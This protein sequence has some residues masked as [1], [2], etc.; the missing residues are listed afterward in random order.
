M[1]SK[2]YPPAVGIVELS[3]Q[4]AYESAGYGPEDIDV[5]QVYDTMAPAELWDIEKLGFCKTG[6]AAAMLRDGVFDIGSKIPVNTDGGLM[7]RGHPLGA[8]GLGQIFE[9][10]TQLRGEAGSRQVKKAKIGLTHA[11]GAGP[12]SSVTILKR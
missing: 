2:K 5:L 8:T 6:E 3:A 10:V 4:Q 7:S 9:I 11:M 12:N 1:V